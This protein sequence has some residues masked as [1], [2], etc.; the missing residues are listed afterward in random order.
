[1][2]QAVVWAASGAEKT[3]GGR[4][5]GAERSCEISTGRLEAVYWPRVMA[6]LLLIEAK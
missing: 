6:R 4:W 5:C 3:H 2:T 1:M